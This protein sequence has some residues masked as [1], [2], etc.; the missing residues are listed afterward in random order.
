MILAAA[1]VK[2]LKD[3]N[4]QYFSE[5]EYPAL[6]GVYIELVIA[7][8]II[9]AAQALVSTG[10]FAGQ[11]TISFGRK[12]VAILTNV[13]GPPSGSFFSEPSQPFV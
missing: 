10:G 3:L 7:Y 9:A 1:G 6:N 13:K 11:R 4:I 8:G 2:M 12:A 5:V